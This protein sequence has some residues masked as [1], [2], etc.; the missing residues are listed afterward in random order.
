MN[1]KKTGRERE[2]EWGNVWKRW[3][4]VE[5]SE[6]NPSVICLNWNATNTGGFAFLS[7]GRMLARHEKQ[8]ALRRVHKN[9]HALLA[10]AI[11]HRTHFIFRFYPHKYTTHFRAHALN[12][13]M[14]KC[15][16]VKY[17]R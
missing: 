8:N 17:I 1:E 10:T 15:S 13:S 5:I 4:I 12:D 14:I 3:E 16:N 9:V 6:R 7:F 2:R 11:V